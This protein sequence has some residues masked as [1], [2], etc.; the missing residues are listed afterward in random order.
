[1]PSIDGHN[2]KF[3]FAFGLTGNGVNFFYL[4]YRFFFKIE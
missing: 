3:C 1:M 2:Y 4:E